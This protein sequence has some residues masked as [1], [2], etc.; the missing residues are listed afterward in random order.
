MQTAE[1]LT[2]EE[3]VIQMLQE[4]GVPIHRLGYQQLCI[5]I[6]YFHTDTTKTLSKDVYPY[7][8]R[9]SGNISPLAVEHSMREVIHAAYECCN[10]QVWEKYFPR[11]QK[12]PSNK[13]FIATL[14]ER[15]K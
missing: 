7:V 13:R 2:R 6:P 3:Q 1:G 10:T 15:L 8:A 14:A 9:Q 11:N 4:L 12:I 5:A